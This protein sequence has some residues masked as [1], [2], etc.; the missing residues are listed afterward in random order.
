MIKIWGRDRM[1]ELKLRSLKGQNG[2]HTVGLRW[3]ER[4]GYQSRPPTTGF[5]HYIHSPTGGWS[6]ICAGFLILSPVNA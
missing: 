1:E 6:R 3:G 5:P 4:R 2:R